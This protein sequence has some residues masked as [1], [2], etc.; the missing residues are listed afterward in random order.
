LGNAISMKAKL[1]IRGILLLSLYP[2]KPLFAQCI[3]DAGPPVHLCLSDQQSHQ[4][5]A[6]IKQGSGPYRVNWMNSGP[7][8]LTFH[9]DDTTVLD[10]VIDYVTPNVPDV[11]I[12][13]RVI[14]ANNDTCYSTVNV[15]GSSFI[16]TLDQTP[17]WVTPGEKDTICGPFYV[18]GGFAPY[19]NFVWQQEL[20]FD[21]GDTTECAI[22]NYA[23]DKS[24]TKYNGMSTYVKAASYTAEDKYGC[25]F[26]E[27]FLV[28]F[29]LAG[30]NEINGPDQVKLFPNPSYGRVNVPENTSF[31]YYEVFDLQGKNLSSKQVI[32]P[33]QKTIDITMISGEYFIRFIDSDNKAYI[34]KCIVE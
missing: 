31:K 20:L 32:E 30:I 17:I 2:A 15:T 13:V 29:Y 12:R 34:G 1:I 10:P 19:K 23:I 27:D 16:N 24:N 21:E 18:L 3:V 5:I 28:G 25:P 6:E 26:G 7:A 4:L 33:G 22:M 14:D 11:H 8:Q 9:M